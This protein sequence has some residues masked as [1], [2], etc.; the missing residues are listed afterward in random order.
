[1]GK[2]LSNNKEELPKIDGQE[3]GR[4]LYQI[5]YVYEL[6]SKRPENDSARQ[7]SISEL[8]KSMSVEAAAYLDEEVA[9]E[10]NGHE[11]NPITR[12]MQIKIRATQDAIK[13]R[14]RNRSQGEKLAIRRNKA[15]SRRGTP[16][17]LIH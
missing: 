11:T 8:S 1:M 3:T 4:R 17:D 13:E 7:E 5:W 9:T 6:S 12:G 14:A 10:V 16:R 15:Q 2:E